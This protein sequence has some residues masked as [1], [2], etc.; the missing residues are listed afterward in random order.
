MAEERVTIN[1][2]QGWGCHEHCFIETHTVDGKIVRTQKANLPGF[3]RVPGKICQKG[4]ANQRVP[5]NE[6]RLLYPLKR[7]GERGEGKFERISWDQALDEIAG[8]INDAKEKYGTR[9][10]IVDAFVCGIPGNSQSVSNI[11][12]DRFV[13]TFSGTKLEYAAMDYANVIAEEIDTGVPTCA[14]RNVICNANDYVMIWGGN[15]IGFTRAA[16][17]TK[18]FL[19][20][21]ERGAK[22]VHISNMFDNTDAKVD[23]WVPIKSAT[24]AALALAMAHVLIRDGYVDEDFLLDDTVAGLLVRTD[25]GKFLRAADLVPQYDNDWFCVFDKK[26]GKVQYTPKQL[27]RHEGYGD[28]EPTLDCEGEVEGIPYKTAFRLLREHLEQWTP[29][30]QEEITGVPA[31]VCEQLAHDFGDAP[32]ALITMGNG[33]RYGNGAEAYR[34][35]RLLSYITGNYCKPGGSIMCTGAQG[36]V[37]DFC[38]QNCS[39]D[40]GID[41]HLA[42]QLSMPD[43]LKSFDDPSMQQHKVL[44]ISEGNPILN[45]PNYELWTKKLLPNFDCVVQFEIRMTDTCNWVDYVLPE[46]IAFER[47]EFLKVDHNCILC[48][49][50]IEPMGEARTAADIWDGIASRVGIGQYFGK[51]QEEWVR[52]FAETAEPHNM[53]YP[54]VEPGKATGNE[55]AVELT[56]EMLQE[57]P[58]WHTAITDEPLDDCAVTPMYLTPTGRIEFY[59]EWYA[60]TPWTMGNLQPTWVLNEEDRKT[61][62]YHFFPGRHK[63]F[64]QGQFTNIDESMDLARGMF[65]TTMNPITAKEKG[66]REGDEIEVF[67]QRG[68]M[69]S[70][71]HLREDVQPGIVWTWYSFP[72]SWY[73]HTDC[74]QVLEQPSNGPETETEFSKLAGQL[75]LHLADV[76]GLHKTGMFISG[77]STPETIFDV[78]CDVR[79]A[80]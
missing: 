26:T 36:G 42:Q 77:E 4:V 18:L 11:L 21:K 9:S 5:Y 37:E 10:T 64:M 47:H 34:A 1:P 65:G 46:T 28:L 59:S 31:E 74:P 20:A 49:P 56:W 73:P 55:E 53:V 6:D 78:L 68:V 35:I 60:G 3:V 57:K 19:D 79:K 51:T 25:T 61:Y 12:S 33:Y 71:V 58:V 62:P 23:Q 30:R 14:G 70:K 39:T 75:T 13:N 22:L 52:I 54:N 16:R 40:P 67:N 48:E 50:A 24:D 29:E 15:P 44:I 72:K 69:R 27:K 80:E 45:W 8:Y 41:P 32:A 43:L 76:M 7:V 17:T 38:G 2:C 63:Y 66:L